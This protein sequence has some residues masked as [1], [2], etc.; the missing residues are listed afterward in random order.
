M[1]LSPK[2]RESLAGH[3]RHVIEGDVLSDDFSRAR[4]ATDAS[5]FQT[6]PALIALPKTQEDLLAAI[7]LAW[8][9]GVSV[10]ARG[11]GTGRSGQAVGE[12]LVLHLAQQGP[13]PAAVRV[14]ALQA[15][16]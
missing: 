9:K 14:M 3:L 10:I 13:L 6:F 1:T 5:P 15:S 16:H 8:D 4:Y 12:G 11:G 7:H 2:A